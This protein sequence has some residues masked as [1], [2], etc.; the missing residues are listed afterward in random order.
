M[1]RPP[2]LPVLRSL[3]VAAIVAACQGPAGAMGPTGPAG[4]AG[5]AG[6]SGA[7]GPT[8]AAGPT[9]ATGP[10]GPAGAPGPAGP[11]GPQGPAGPTANRM[12]ATGRFDASGTFTMPLPASAVANN[13]L[14]FIACYVSTNQQTWISVAQVPVSASD[15]YCGVTGIGTPTP[16]ITIINGIEGDYYYILAVW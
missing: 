12:Q 11:A 1:P 10:Q 14:P 2:F 13:T 5:P 4:P 9:G 16:G 6:P 8:G 7:T 15:T 3:L